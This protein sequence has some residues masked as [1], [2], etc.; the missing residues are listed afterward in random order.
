[1]PQV[2]HWT[3]S[4]TLPSGTTGTKNTVTNRRPERPRYGRSAQQ[5][6]QFAPLAADTYLIVNQA[7]GKCLDVNDA[8][9]DNGANIQQ[10]D[11]HRGPNQQWKVQWQDS[12]FALVSVNSGRCVAIEDDKTSQRDCDNGSDQ[13]WTVQALS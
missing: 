4:P 10:W 2:R 6:W 3:C 5:R 12:S 7:S 11:C 13:R 9:R 8:S 1:M